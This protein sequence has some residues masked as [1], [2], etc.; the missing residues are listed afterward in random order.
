[1]KR[2][3]LFIISI[4]LVLSVVGCNIFSNDLSDAIESLSSEFFKNE[5]N[6]ENDAETETEPSNLLDETTSSALDNTT[7]VTADTSTGDTEIIEKIL[8][9]PAI[10]STATETSSKE[11]TENDYI[12]V[13]TIELD[14]VEDAE[15]PSISTQI[16]ST[17]HHTALSSASYYQYS[18]LS[19]TEKKIYEDIRKS[20]ETG[21]TV[22]DVSAYG[23]SIDTVYTAYIAVIS[24]HPQ[25]FYLNKSFAYTYSARKKT[26]K[27]II[28]FY[29]DGNT[30]DEYNGNGELISSADRE[31]ISRQIAEF[32]NKIDEIVSSISSDISDFE[33]EKLIYEYLQNTVVY[34][35]NAAAAVLSSSEISSHAFDVYGAACEGLAVCEGYSELFQYLCYC[36]GINATPVYGTASGVSHM[37]NAVCLDNE[38]YMVDV[39]WDDSAKEGLYCYSYF[40]ITETEIQ[41]NHDIDYE[42][43]QVPSCTATSYAYYNWYA[44]Y[45]ESTSE[46]PTNY[47][48]VIDYLSAS[49]YQYLCVYVGNQTGNLQKYIQQYILSSRS[50]LQ[51][52]IA[53]NNC[54]ISFESTYYSIGN[55]YYIPIVYNH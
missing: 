29:F 23:C 20:I 33:K 8:D 24:D 41:R 48:T 5:T 21:A 14:T 44:L 38:W 52:Y 34:D 19:D 54:A 11:T 1:M 42:T 45:I 47:Q 40:N 37:W 35:T 31:L 2:V 10:Q 46:A 39:T 4:M 30:S 27:Q 6:S 28:L 9:V 25:F 16:E 55:Y 7:S 36:V 15:I 51:K 13:E 43:L 32:N 12:E 53:S 3:A 22:I 50:A 26:I 18:G 17:S 49:N